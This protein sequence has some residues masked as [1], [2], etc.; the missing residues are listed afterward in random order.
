MPT[1]PFAEASGNSWLPRVN[2]DGSTVT[3]DVDRYTDFLTRAVLLARP[4]FR[5]MVLRSMQAAVS[6]PCILERL[7]T[8]AGGS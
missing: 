7:A 1:R 3:G 2:Y 6:A 5:T 8:R 4:W